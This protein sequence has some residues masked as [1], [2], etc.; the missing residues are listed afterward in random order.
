MNTR[1]L[2]T[3]V[4]ATMITAAE[5]LLFVWLLAPAPVEATATAST[6]PYEA[7]PVVVVTAPRHP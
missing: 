3:L 5:S 7:L 6:S 1:R 4:A 2:V